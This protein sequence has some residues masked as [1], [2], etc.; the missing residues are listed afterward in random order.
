MTNETLLR[1]LENE[2]RRYALELMP[3]DPSGEMAQLPLA[4]LRI[5]YLTWRGRRVSPRPRHVLNSRE[6]ESSVPTAH[7]AGFD[8]LVE[9]IQ[10]GDDLTPHLS[11]RVLTAYVP[12]AEAK[13]TK[14]H[15]LWDRDQL[16]SEWGIHHLHLGTDGANGFVDRTG[17]LLFAYFTA[18]AA[19]LIGIFGHGD[20]ALQAVAEIC[21]RNWPEAGIFRPIEAIALSQEYNDDDLLELR[22]GGVAVPLQ[23]DGKVYSPRFQTTAGTPLEATMGANRVHWRLEE[24]AREP[25]LEASLTVSAEGQGSGE[26]RPFV[27]DD[28]FGFARDGDPELHG[29]DVHVVCGRIG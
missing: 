7:R 26:W 24:L 17:S 20:W 25:D 12:S 13:N 19:Y 9:R 18:E 2:L 21:I 14:T 8:L 16:I 27:T 15:Q 22:K 29:G 1:A 5:V 10:R 28:C 6:L 3:D 23:I 4:D 11:K